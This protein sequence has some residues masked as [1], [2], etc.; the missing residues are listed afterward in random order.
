MSA[1]E[2]PLASGGNVWV[3][4]KK[5]TAK[6]TIWLSAVAILLL[7]IPLFFYQE[8]PSVSA[9]GATLD[10]GGNTGPNQQVMTVLGRL[11]PTFIALCLFGVV[12]IM[13]YLANKHNPQGRR[14]SMFRGFILVFI[15]FNLFVSCRTFLWAIEEQSEWI[16]TEL[17]STATG[18][19]FEGSLPVDVTNWEDGS[20]HTITLSDGTEETFNVIRAS[21][22]IVGLSKPGDEVTPPSGGQDG[23][24]STPAPTPTPEP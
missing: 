16:A 19:A 14:S 3:P 7:L 2:A 13:Y 15:A 22:S 10:I 8:Y 17:G 9:D 21:N 24:I 5:S 12:Y 20:T 6:L 18:I 1:N 23:I 11:L 4:P